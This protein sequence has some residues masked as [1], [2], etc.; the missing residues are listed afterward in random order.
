MDDTEIVDLYWKRE[1][2]AVEETA[3]KYGSFC[4]SIAY[5]VLSNHEDSEESVN[6]TYLGAWNTMPPKHPPILSTFLGRITRNIA[7]KRYREKKGRKKRRGI[8]K[9]IKKL[10]K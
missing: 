9:Y 4:Y 1:E 2:R 8:N 3:K 7:F 10:Y 5:N 6:D